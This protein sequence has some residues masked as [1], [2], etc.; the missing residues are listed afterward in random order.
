MNIRPLLLAVPLLATLVLTGCNDR[1]A[2]T[3]SPTPITSPAASATGGSSATAAPVATLPLGTGGAIPAIVTQVIAAVAT[4]Q[5][6]AVTTLLAYQQV[7]CTTAQ[8]AGG[9]PKCKPGD[10]AGTVYRVFAT[11]TCEGEWVE[12]AQTRIADLVAASGPMY[13][14][15]K[16]KA[17]S[18]DPE[19]YWP[20]GESLIYFR[21]KGG[22]P[23]TYFI[24]SADRI[25]RAHRICDLHD[26]PQ[27]DAF[28][29][30][31]GGTEYLVPPSVPR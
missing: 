18:P 10:A 9:P 27:A 26:Q 14:A 17:P 21:G 15:V 25:V 8:G 19:P 2:P 22:T 12:N 16:V 30:K 4:G 11:G 6:D 28:I 5:A 1:G 29:Q 7:G 20:K 24:M 3:P 13:A 31:L 23:G